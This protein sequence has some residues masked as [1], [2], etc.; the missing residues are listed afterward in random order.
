MWV[1]T[2]AVQSNNLLSIWSCLTS[3]IID[4]YSLSHISIGVLRLPENLLSFA[5]HLRTFRIFAWHLITAA[6]CRTFWKFV[7]HV[8]RIQQVSG[9]LC[10]LVRCHFVTFAGHMKQHCWTF[11]DFRWTVNLTAAHRE[12]FCLRRTF[13]KFAQHVRHGQRISESMCTPARC[14]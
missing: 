9:I 14:W 6:H 1:I 10:T 13:W 8:R 3:G 4:T 2:E 12:T 7:A 5:R 11:E